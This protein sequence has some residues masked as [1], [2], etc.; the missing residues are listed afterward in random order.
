[1]NAVFTTHINEVPRDESDDI[2]AFLYKHFTKS[3]FQTRFRWRPNSVAF[4]DN[5]CTQHI[6]VNDVHDTARHM[7]RTQIAG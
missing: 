6:A 4:W 3:I 1:M 7:R 2:L 5:R